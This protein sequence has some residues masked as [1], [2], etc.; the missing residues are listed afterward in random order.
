MG[1]LS[2]VVWCVVP[3]GPWWSVLGCTFLDFWNVCVP[4]FINVENMFVLSV[5]EGWDKGNNIQM[6]ECVNP[7]LLIG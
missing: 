4:L 5:G 3:S 1:V 6:Y 2:L 7:L